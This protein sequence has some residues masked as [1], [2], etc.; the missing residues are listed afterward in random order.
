MSKSNKFYCFSINNYKKGFRTKDCRDNICIGATLEKLIKNRKKK[1]S[2][3]YRNFDV[4]VYEMV[5]I[6][7]I[8]AGEKKLSP[9][10]LL[11]E[12]N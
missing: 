11:I 1:D 2:C 5:K 7:V 6:G 9:N 10:P 12:I 3:D 4:V 8:K